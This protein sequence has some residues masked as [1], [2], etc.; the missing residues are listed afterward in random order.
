MGLK[1]P[2]AHE[3]NQETTWPSGRHRPE[4]GQDRP[5][6]G[7]RRDDCESGTEADDRDEGDLRH[8]G[9][10]APLPDQAHLQ[11]MFGSLPRQ[12]AMPS[13]RD[14]EMIKQAYESPAVKAMQ[15]LFKKKD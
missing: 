14:L 3:R 1:E 2:H 10:L 7:C 11:A 9:I 12:L 5:G 13:A 15:A 6:A 4:D 8:G